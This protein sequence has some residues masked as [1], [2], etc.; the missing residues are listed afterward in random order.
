MKTCEQPP[1]SGHDKCW[2]HGIGKPRAEHWQTEHSR[3][4]PGPPRRTAH[5]RRSVKVF[6]FKV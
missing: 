1:Y 2:W 5:A 6:T 3:R 4:R